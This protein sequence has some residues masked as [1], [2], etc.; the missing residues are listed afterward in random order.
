MCVWSAPL[1]RVCLGLPVI[2]SDPAGSSGGSVFVCR[3]CFS[4]SSHSLRAVAEVQQVLLIS[5]DNK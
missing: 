2:V 1:C 4:H 5:I 3:V